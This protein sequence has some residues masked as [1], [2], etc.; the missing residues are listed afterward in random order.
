MPVETG[1]VAVTANCLNGGALSTRQELLAQE[2]PVALAYNGI[3]HAVMMAS[4]LDLEDFAL[5]FSLS[6][7]I[8]AARHELTDIE[9]VHGSAGI[10]VQMQILAPRFLALKTLRRSLTGRTGCGLCGAESLETAI[11]PIRAVPANGFRV[12]AQQVSAAARQ[13]T[14]RQPLNQLTGAMHAAGLLHAGQMLVREDVGRHN[15]L[16]KLIGAATPDALAHGLLVMTSR[17]SYEIVHKAAAAQIP[18][19]AAISAP[20]TLAVQLAKEA[21][22]TLLGFVREERMT[23]YTHA[24]RL[25]EAPLT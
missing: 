23:V 6:E 7:G 20:T 5:G 1:H 24:W 3:S 18:V 19:L 8:I 4:P 11:R 15:A 9:V 10:I 25:G 22:M 12:T 21:G 13:L 16:D 2:T 17:A 14:E